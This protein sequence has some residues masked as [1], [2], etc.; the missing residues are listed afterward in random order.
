[1]IKSSF[2]VGF[3]GFL[4]GV[5]AGLGIA[6]GAALFI[7]ASPVPFVDKVDKV[8]ADVDPAQ[9]LAGRV[10]PNAR[11]N[12]SGISQET[13]EHEAAG[14][15][16]TVRVPD[17]ASADQPERDAS[18]KAIGPGVVTPV[19]YW[20][21]VAAFAK[22][23]DAETAAASLAM[24]GIAAKV[25]QAGAFWRVRV[26]PFDDRSAAQEALENLADMGQKPVITEEK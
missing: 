22:K 15:V 12:Q 19:T 26:G 9:K 8:T 23:P 16:K 1:M 3:A 2:S 7:A 10:D 13:A 25:A 24:Q 18:G 17:A 14:G 6:A 20:V 21:Q 11:L 5:V 4:I